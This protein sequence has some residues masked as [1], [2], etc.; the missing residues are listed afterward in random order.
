MT[1]WL[2]PLPTTPTSIPNPP[3]PGAFGV[4][5]KFDNHTGVD[6]YA[7]DRTPVLA[8]ESGVVVKVLPFTGPSAGSPWW[9]ETQA[10]LVAG[11]SGVVCYGEVEPLVQ[12]G[13]TVVRGTPLGF[14][15]QV[16]P[17]SKVRSDIPGHMSSMLHLELYESGTSQPVEWLLGEAK[18]SNLLNPTWKLLRSEW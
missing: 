5:R 3:H 13:M 9:L 14:V 18:P 11:D 10:I 1:S 17:D 12:E 2:W 4:A 15:R 16:L 6:L 7:P 8:V